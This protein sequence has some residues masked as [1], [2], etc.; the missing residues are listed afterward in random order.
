M[1]NIRVTTSHNSLLQS[2]LL[3][4]LLHT[5]SVYGYMQLTSKQ[6]DERGNTLALEL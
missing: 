6:M 4:T 2:E 3:I 1:L 5:F